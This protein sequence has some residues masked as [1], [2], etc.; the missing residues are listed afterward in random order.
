[1]HYSRHYQTNAMSEPLYR[2][3]QA[4]MPLGPGMPCGTP[5]ALYNQLER[6]SA[7]IPHIIDSEASILENMEEIL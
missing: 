1:V 5:I 6:F 7:L 4:S 2:I 3:V